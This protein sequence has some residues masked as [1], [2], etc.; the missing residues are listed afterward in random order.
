VSSQPQD[1]EIPVHDGPDPHD[2]PEVAPKMWGLVL[3]I[4]VLN[5][6]IE[7][8]DG[9][10]PLGLERVH[11]EAREFLNG[12]RETQRAELAVMVLHAF[13]VQLPEE[14]AGLPT[15]AVGGFH[16]DGD[17]PGDRDNLR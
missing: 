12:S 9:R 6:V 17:G 1:E 16:G 15:E 14:T 11:G 7:A 2:W 13:R 3:D 10:V 8:I 4:E 5:R